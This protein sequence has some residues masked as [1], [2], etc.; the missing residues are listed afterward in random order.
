MKRFIS[1]VLTAVALVALSVVPAF[2]AG[3]SIEVSTEEASPGSSVTL[4]FTMSGNP[5]IAAYS[6]DLVYDQSALELTAL[7]SGA[8]F[9][10]LTFIK[11][12]P[13]S[14]VAAFSAYNTTANG[15]MFTATFR[16]QDDA[17]E[18]FAPVSLSV[19]EMAS[20]SYVSYT[21]TITS[22]GVTVVPAPAAS[23]APETTEEPPASGAPAE[24]GSPN[25]PP[26][27]DDSPAGGD[28]PSGD[29]SPVGGVPS[30]GDNSPA[31][32]QA[33]TDDVLGNLSD[34]LTAGAFTG[35]GVDIDAEE[36]LTALGI[37]PD[38]PLSAA[39]DSATGEV[40]TGAAP[41]GEPEQL[42]DV[43]EEESSETASGASPAVWIIPVLA[44]V[45][46]AVVAYIIIYRK[47]KSAQSAPD[48]EE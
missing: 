4:T 27:G 21:P 33:Q 5:G 39:I 47:K 11:Y 28:S 18:G 30:A 29:D 36:L 8:D 34:M 45:C 23:E 31:G 12:I 17:K 41:I 19:T 37:D 25:N 24:T 14:R 10:A 43:A 22:G 3:P 48:K 13:S 26:A 15:V 46:A 6:A 40:L 9:R 38:A 16:V 2:A 35:D 20:G 44:V 7:A 32:G 1:A 42:P